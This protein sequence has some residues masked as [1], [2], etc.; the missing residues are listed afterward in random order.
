LAYASLLEQKSLIDSAL[1]YL[2]NIPRLEKNLLAAEALYHMSRLY[3]AQQR[4][5][6]ARAA[7]YRL[8]DELPAYLEPRAK[9]YLILARIFLAENKRKSARQLLESLIENAPTE[10]IR[11]EA[12]LL[13]DSIPPDP[14]P[15][16]SKPS[17]KKKK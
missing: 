8:R 12:R 14:P 17:G 5:A 10:A 11:A 1:F 7:I 2:Q 9:A 16:P 6:E 3:Y 15:A 4:Y 13:K